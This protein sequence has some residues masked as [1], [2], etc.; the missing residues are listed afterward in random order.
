MPPEVPGN[1]PWHASLIAR[2]V[3]T[4]WDYNSGGVILWDD[5]TM[6]SYESE[7]PAGSDQMEW[8]FPHWFCGIVEKKPSSPVWERLTPDSWGL[9]QILSDTPDYP[10]WPRWDNRT[11]YNNPSLVMTEGPL[12]YSAIG[13][14]NTGW[15]HVKLNDEEVLFYGRYTGADE[16]SAITVNRRTRRWKRH[17]GSVLTRDTWDNIRSNIVMVGDDLWFFTAPPVCGTP[18]MHL[19]RVPVSDLTEVN[20]MQSYE[21]PTWLNVPNA[22]VIDLPTFLDNQYVHV[23][24]AQIGYDPGRNRIYVAEPSFNKVR[25]SRTTAFTSNTPSARNYDIQFLRLRSLSLDDPE[26][27]LTLDY[28]HHM[29]QE[30][31]GY[32]QTGNGYGT[33]YDDTLGMFDMEDGSA[34]VDGYTDPIG[35]GFL[36]INREFNIVDGWIYWFDYGGIG[37][38]FNHLG[39]GNYGCRMN[40]ADIPPGGRRKHNPYDPIIEVI[41]NGTVPWEGAWS[42]GHWNRG[43][44]DF[45]VERAG[46]QPILGFPD[47]TTTFDSE[48]NIWYKGVA[49]MDYQLLQKDPG[50]WAT[51]SIWKLSP[52]RSLE[53]VATVTFTG[54]ELKG[55]AS[56][57]QV[58]K[59]TYEIEVA[60]G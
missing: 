26:F 30:W 23:N 54:D 51:R 27:G 8:D 9:I 44:G 39:I 19:V 42:R 59:G 24:D 46:S 32:G 25:D 37:G 36:P 5:G 50:G 22:K 34:V 45:L 14:G 13:Y 1:K 12:S 15:C 52:T 53:T 49:L 28:Y 48:G 18:V 58:P 10:Q 35:I 43:G 21:W 33:L 47:Q 17:V 4:D 3:D 29:P 41:T 16:L 31:I 57:R 60:L 20:Y 38:S 7:S 40:L 2:T 56:V 11:D 55:Y 6:W